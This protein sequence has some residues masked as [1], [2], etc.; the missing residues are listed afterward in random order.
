MI[1]FIDEE[2]A[3][4]DLRKAYDALSAARHLKGRGINIPDH[5]LGNIEGVIETLENRLIELVEKNDDD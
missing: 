2:L 4:R 5:V 3:K 1:F